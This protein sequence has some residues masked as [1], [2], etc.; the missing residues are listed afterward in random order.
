MADGPYTTTHD[1]K[2]PFRMPALSSRKIITHRFYVD[3]ARGYEGI[4]YYMI[5]CRDLMVQIVPKG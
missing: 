3:N 1:V 5:I 4:G 2:V